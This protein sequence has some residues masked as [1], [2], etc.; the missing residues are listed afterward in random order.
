MPLSALC[1]PCDGV[2]VV[3]W[4]A[5]TGRCRFRKGAQRLV[6][7]PRDGRKRK[8][9]PAADAHKNRK[10]RKMVRFA[11]RFVRVLKGQMWFRGA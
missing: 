10:P 9:H 6:A 2:N 1:P 5:G 3:R 11:R 8:A 4:T 7:E